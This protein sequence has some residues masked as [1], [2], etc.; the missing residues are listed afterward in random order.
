MSAFQQKA[1]LQVQNI[2][3]QCKRFR[4]KINIQR[5]RP[6][7]YQRALFNAVTTP[8]YEKIP[9]TVQCRARE[10]AFLTREKR[11]AESHPYQ[12][13]LARELLECFERSN[14]TLV[15]HKNPIKAYDMFK[16][17]VLLHKKEIQCKVYGKKIVKEAL[18]NT[19]YETLLPLFNVSNCI[20]FASEP[21]VNDVLKLLRKAPQI[22]LLGGIV[23]NQLLSKNELV[24][25]SQL[26]N[27]AIV[28]AQFAANLHLAGGSILNKL[29]AHQSNLCYLLDAHAKG[30]GGDGNAKTE[31]DET[32][33]GEGV[34][35]APELESPPST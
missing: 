30:L 33:N 18:S 13:I 2:L 9:M 12:K 10:E 22:I 23:D 20:L 32:A 11:E 7:H 15:C 3:V 14:M 5:P 1:F 26:P 35:K 19:K 4:G 28:Q 29:Q 8:I 27:L 21:K 16:F 17:R 6:P 25:Y 34:E 31:G 24:S